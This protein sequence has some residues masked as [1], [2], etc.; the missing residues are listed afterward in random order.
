MIIYYIESVRRFFLKE[1][2][3]KKIFLLLILFTIF[4]CQQSKADLTHLT[5][6]IIFDTLSCPDSTQLFREL[7]NV[8]SQLKNDPDNKDLLNKKLNILNQLKIAESCDPD[9]DLNY[10]HENDRKFWENEL[11]EINLLKKDD[12]LHKS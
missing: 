8:E 10:S 3:M 1:S 5:S 6:S 11:K 12:G 7:G 4:N 2:Y 9:Y